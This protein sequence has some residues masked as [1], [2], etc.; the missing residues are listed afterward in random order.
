[1]TIRKII[2]VVALLAAANVAFAGKIAIFN[3]ENAIM[4]TQAASQAVEKL[5]AD[6]GYAR[7]MTQIE[8]LQADLKAL[9]KESESKG[10]TWSQEQVASHRKKMEYVQA[11]LQLVAKKIQ[12][13][14]AAVINKLAQEFQP[15]MQ[16]VLDTI[17]KADGIDIVLR[18]QSVYTVMPELDITAKVTAGLDKSL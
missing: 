13:E 5:K 14:N 12:A 8:S 2:A 16:G 6:A 7:M 1:M 15:K 9:A 11:D 3:H 4:A 10:I 18:P 17:M